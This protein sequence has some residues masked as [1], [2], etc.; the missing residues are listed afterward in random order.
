[1]QTARPFSSPSHPF[2]AKRLSRERSG[3]SSATAAHSFS[4]FIS[5]SLRLSRSVPALLQLLTA[6]GIGRRMLAREFLSLLTL[7]CVFRASGSAVDG[8]DDYE[9]MYVNLDNE[10]E[11]PATEEGE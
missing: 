11:G 3:Y 2:P 4:G 5:G 1:M 10:I 7:L 9:L 8:E 6:P